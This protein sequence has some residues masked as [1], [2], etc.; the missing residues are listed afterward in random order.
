MRKS[1]F[2]R[3]LFMSVPLLGDA[4]VQ[5]GIVNW[6]ADRSRELHLVSHRRFLPTIKHLYSSHSS[7][8]VVGPDQ[9]DYFDWPG[10]ISENQLSCISE[11]DME[12]HTLVVP[13]E[14]QQ[15]SS[16]SVP[17]NWDQQMY[18]FYDLSFSLRYTNFRLPRDLS[19]SQQLKTALLGS[20][21]GPYAVIHSQW[22]GTNCDVW[23]WILARRRSLDLPIDIPLIRIDPSLSASCLAWYDLIIGASEV[24]CVPSGPQCFVD[25]IWDRCSGQLYY[26][27]ARVETHIA[28]NNRYNQNCW[29]IE[30]YENRLD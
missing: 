11:P 10:Y 19:I 26:H 27:W 20:Y 28:V 25:S 24:H 16:C 22:G 2:D 13:R 8:R 21:D 30:Q 1:I 18:E 4:F 15:F 17:I 5:N 12:F 7:V 14:G 3:M 9:H 29:Q 23:N 6:F